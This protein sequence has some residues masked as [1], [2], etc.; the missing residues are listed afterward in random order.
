MLELPEIETLRRETEREIAGR[1]LK[2]VDADPGR[3]ADGLEPSD[4]LRLEGAKVASVKRR[5]GHLVF[6]ID[7]GDRL[8]LEIVNGVALRRGKGD[9]PAW[10][11]LGFTQGG[12]VRALEGVGN[13]RLRLTTL[14]E[15]D[16]VVPPSKAIDLA[17]QAVSWVVFAR[18]FV[19]AGGPLRRLLTD[20]AMVESIGPLYADEILWQAGLRPDRRADRLGSQEL[21]RLYRSTAE[22]LHDALKA[23]GTTTAANGFSDL[24]GKP[25][26]Y[27][28][29]LEVF[30][31]D[32]QPCRRCR[33]TVVHD[34]L[35]GALCYR[36]PECQ[37]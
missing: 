26:G 14:A 34:K 31:R 24:A 30:G 35:D 1:K 9:E 28:E 5:G 19:G 7:G 23:G 16:S 21:R 12:P 37:V 6:N 11:E 3:L 17:E 22:V 4:L 2:A 36:C 25:G 29:L 8:L 20:P 15:L 10:I 18:A 27:Q 32:G 13:P 33:G